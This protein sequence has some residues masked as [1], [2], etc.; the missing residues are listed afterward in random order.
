MS[1]YFGPSPVQ[2]IGHKQQMWRKLENFDYDPALA[3]IG[4]L[5]Y[6]N[7]RKTHSTVNMY[8]SLFNQPEGWDQRRPRCDR[9]LVSHIHPEI[10]EE[11]EGK[12]VPVLW[13]LSYGRPTLPQIDYPAKEFARRPQ[14]ASFYRR[15]NLQI[16]LERKA[17]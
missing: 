16:E 2:T 17:S 13:S 7:N 9:R 15:L 8:D 6:F 5:T 3:E 11:E 4:L 14:M 12:I 1:A 10:Y